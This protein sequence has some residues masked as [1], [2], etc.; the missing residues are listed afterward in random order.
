MLRKYVS[1][2]FVLAAFLLLPLASQASPVTFS[3][4][5]EGTVSNSDLKV[6]APP[7]PF[8]VNSDTTTITTFTLFTIVLPNGTFTENGSFE[9][10]FNFTQPSFLDLAKPFHFTSS[11]N[12]AGV[13]FTV[14]QTGEQDI[15]LGGVNYHLT[16]ALSQMSLLPGQ[17]TNI[18]ATLTPTAAVPEPATMLLL[19][20][21]LVGALGSRR[22]RRRFTKR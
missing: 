6:F 19:G 1:R 21:G 4:F 15:T 11:G 8:N 12:Q 22:V 20:T 13:T 7:Q 2:V 16:F 9:F 18:T 10:G 17:S 14:T 5:V 3:G